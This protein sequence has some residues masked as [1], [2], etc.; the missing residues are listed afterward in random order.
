[1]SDAPPEGLIRDRGPDLPRGAACYRTIGPFTRETIPAGL[2]RRHDLK[3]GAWG[4]VTIRAGEI[5]FAWDDEAGGVTHLTA[6]QAILV[7]PTV[8]HHLVLAGEVT[9]DIGFWGADPA[10]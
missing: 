9:L 10:A 8:P 7:P 4:V 1:M 2:L 5:D 6:G 3:P